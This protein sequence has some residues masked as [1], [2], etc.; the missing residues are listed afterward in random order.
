MYVRQL[1]RPEYKKTL[2]G[3]PLLD[4]HTHIA[5]G[6]IICLMKEGKCG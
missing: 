2:D 5:H 6:V 3:V 4:I 1:Q